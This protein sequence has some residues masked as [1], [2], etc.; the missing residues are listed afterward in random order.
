M[1]ITIQSTQQIVKVQ[2]NVEARI[3]EGTTDTGI[4]IFCMITRIGV[5]ASEMAEQF[6]RELRECKPPTMV[7]HWPARMIL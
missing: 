2:G 5:G 3:W 6:D 1:K 4:P 7:N